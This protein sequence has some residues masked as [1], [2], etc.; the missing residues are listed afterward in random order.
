[1]NLNRRVRQQRINYRAEHSRR[2][3][4]S[5]RIICGAFYLSRLNGESIVWRVSDRTGRPR[6]VSVW[7]ESPLAFL[8]MQHAAN[9]RARRTYWETVHAK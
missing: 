8:S 6:I 7:Q 5:I 9:V 2:L 3:H 1:M 4:E